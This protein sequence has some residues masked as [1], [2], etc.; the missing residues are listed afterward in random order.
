MALIVKKFGGTSIK[1][2]EK[3]L[4][5]ANIIKKDYD[6]GNDVVVVVSAQG[7]TTDVLLNKAKEITGKPSARELDVLLSTGEMITISLLAITLEK[8]G[9]PSISFTGY[10]AGFLT[11]INY[12]NSRIINIDTTR[13]KSQLQ[14]NKVVIIAGFQGINKYDDITTLGR[15][16]SDTS[17]VAIAASLMAQ[18]C[19]I[20]TDV[21][22]VYS[23]DPRFIKNSK[24]IKL[25]N[26]DEMLELAS[27]GAKVLHNRSVEMAKRYNVTLEVLTTTGNTKSTIVKELRDMEKLLVT[28]IAKDENISMI[29]ICNITH[30]YNSIFKM[31]SILATKKIA[32]DIMSQSH[33]LNDSSNLTIT[34]ASKD[35]TNAYNLLKENLNILSAKDIVIDADVAKISVVGAA[36]Q[37]NIEAITNIFKYLN[38]NRIYT[39][40]ISMSEIKV[41][42]LVKIADA[43]KTVSIIHDGFFERA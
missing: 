23:S 35:A 4:S 6:K 41:S 29:T 12:N 8:I 25:V 40:L 10:Q 14:K 27:A 3:L 28:G 11:D 13:I 39:K 5:A 34:I 9:C 24:H 38:D 43:D 31:L 16:G 2:K 15:G 21:D 19:Q 32:V 17:A 7:D 42:I 37:S 22:G 33:I 1:D 20:Y 26:Y 30:N 36:L 18:K